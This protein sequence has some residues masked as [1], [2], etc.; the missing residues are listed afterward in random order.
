MARA[1]ETGL[2]TWKGT[3]VHE[4]LMPLPLMSQMQV[5]SERGRDV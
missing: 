4:A 3:S 1:E 2:W 5:K